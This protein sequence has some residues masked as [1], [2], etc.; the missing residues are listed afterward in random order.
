MGLLSKSGPQNPGWTKLLDMGDSKGAAVLMWGRLTENTAGHTGVSLYSSVKWAA[1]PRLAQG[2]PQGGCLPS[3]TFL[4]TRLPGAACLSPPSH[5]V[6]E[7]PSSRESRLSPGQPS[8]GVSWNPHHP[9]LQ[10]SPREHE[11]ETSWVKLGISF[12]SYFSVSP[13][14]PSVVW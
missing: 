1:R 6:P 3:S 5:V 7:I 14:F 13:S 4:H 10:A 12:L 11:L 2:L 9:R 8:G